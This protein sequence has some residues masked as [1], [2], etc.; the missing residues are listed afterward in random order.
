MVRLVLQSRCTS[1]APEI[2]DGGH[3]ILAVRLEEEST[4]CC[5][6]TEII[7]LTCDEQEGFR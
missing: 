3:D 1:A 4:I 7:P 6:I 2:G 5:K